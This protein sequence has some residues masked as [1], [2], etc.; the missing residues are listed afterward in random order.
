MKEVLFKIRINVQQEKEIDR[1]KKRISELIVLRKKNNGLTAKEDVELKSLRK[2]YNGLT[3]AVIKQNNVSKTEANTLGRVNAQLAIEKQRIKAVVIGSKEF[4]TVAARIKNLE[5]KQRAANAAMGRGTTFV[6]EYAKGAIQAFQK[7]AGGVMAAV[8]ALRSMG[9]V[10]KGIIDTL[11]EFQQGQMN[12]Q[13]LLEDFDEELRDES[14]ELIRKYGLA[15][16]DTNRALFDAVS[17]GVAARDSFG[18]MNDAAILAIAGVSDMESV[19]DGMTTVMNVWNVSMEDMNKVS[20]AFFSAQKKGKFYVAGITTEIGKVA[21]IANVANMSY[22]ELMATYAELTKR[23]LPLE[24]STTAIKAA[25]LA[26]SKPSDQAAKAFDKMGI[27][28]GLTAVAEQGLFTIL[29]K[30]NAATKDEK[31][32]L[33]ELIP[34]IRAL[35][36]VTIL[37]DEALKD[38]DEILKIVNEDFGEGSSIM[39]GYELQM[40]T[41]TK[42]KQLLK[43][44][45]DALILSSREGNAIGRIWG[46]ILTELTGAINKVKVGSERLALASDLLFKPDR[47]T[48]WMLYTEELKKQFD[49]THGLLTEEE[50]LEEQRKISAKE[51]E[52]RQAALRTDE[53]E[54]KKRKEETEEARKARYEAQKIDEQQAFDDK[55]AK[56]QFLFEANQAFDAADKE[57]F[58]AVLAEYYAT[59]EEKKLFRDVLDAEN[60]ESVVTF[61]DTTLSLHQK[62]WEAEEQ[63]VKD[64]EQRKKGIREASFAAASNALNAFGNLFE[65]AKQKELSAVGD[66]AKAREEIEKKYAKKQQKIAIGQAIISGAVG[67]QK[68]GANLGYPL[69]IPFQIVQAIATIAQIAVIKAQKFA[70]GGKVKGIGDKDTVEAMLTPGEGI[71]NKKSMQSSDTMSLTGTPHDIASQ[72]NSYKGFGI[73]F[74]SGGVAGSTTN[75]TYN[76]NTM[77]RMQSDISDIKVILNMNEVSEGLKE[78]N[79]IQQTGE[80]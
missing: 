72:L 35:T 66:N 3:N 6:G 20:A 60:L 30:V 28:T 65:S 2:D 29:K 34:N 27:E 79:V 22:Q 69:A 52:K 61:L 57:V 26:V 37:S 59:E 68:T 38:Y 14:I 62:E 16:N 33:T 53:D 80:I 9:R 32:L 73:P 4:N 47:L 75:N 12:V 45:W 39:K 15:I 43:A 1:L 78:I 67:I 49:A 63:G 19:V 56:M 10:F 76:Y 48:T 74:A 51:W 31:D 64:S 13:T 42:K 17:A 7:I 8:V 41:L 18:F 46:G 11:T 5:N 40:T 70:L 50:K 23:G 58:D 71:I 25:I 21:S 55:I 77:D 24:L 36:G 44:E 54:D